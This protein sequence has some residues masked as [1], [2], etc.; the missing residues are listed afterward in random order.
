MISGTPFQETIGK[1]PLVA[2][3][4]LFFWQA[5]LRLT[6]IRSLTRM[7]L[8]GGRDRKCLLCNDDGLWYFG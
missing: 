5:V 1:L 7:V 8:S 3:I 6:L 4:G 2:L